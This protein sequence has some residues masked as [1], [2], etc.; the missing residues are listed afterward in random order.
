[1]NDLASM[2]PMPSREVGNTGY[3]NLKVE[4]ELQDVEPVIEPKPGLMITARWTPKQPAQPVDPSKPDARISVRYPCL[5]VMYLPAGSTRPSS[6]RSERLTTVFSGNQ[7]RPQEALELGVAGLAVEETTQSP[8]WFVATGFYERTVKFLMVFDQAVLERVEQA[9]RGLDFV[10]KIIP[11][12]EVEEVGYVAPGH[13]NT[14]W[15]ADSTGINLEF[16]RSKWSDILQAIGYP[17]LGPP[18]ELPLTTPASKAAQVHFREALRQVNIDNLADAVVNA[19]RAL[20]ELRGAVPPIRPKPN[21]DDYRNEDVAT[22]IRRA[23]WAAFNLCNI[24]AHKAGATSFGRAEAVLAIQLVGAL[25][26]YVGAEESSRKMALSAEP[27]IPTTTIDADY[28]DTTASRV[29]SPLASPN[30]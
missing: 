1:M 25:I 8:T 20:E 29:V 30:K 16:P 24:T 22:R 6:G 17:S 21:D 19:R 23:A 3:Q 10:L 13:A 12:G 2:T 15:L 11:R 5:Q 27:A 18:P 9:R 26:N 28:E 4:L 14:Y 7:D